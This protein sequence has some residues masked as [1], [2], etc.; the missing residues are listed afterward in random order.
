MKKNEHK[1][2][3]KEYW[4]GVSWSDPAGAVASEGAKST[5]RYI[6]NSPDGFFINCD[7]GFTSMKEAN[8][9]FARWVEALAQQGYYSQTCY[10]GYRRQISLAHL[11]DYCE[12]IKV[13]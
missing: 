5:K 2:N 7:G 4:A 3:L 8:A 11:A 13:K 1:I 9:Y 6:I 10:N 12:F